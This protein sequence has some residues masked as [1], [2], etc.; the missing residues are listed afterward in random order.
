MSRDPVDKWLD[1]LWFEIYRLQFTPNQTHANIL[2]SQ[3]QELES[4]PVAEIAGNDF[5]TMLQNLETLKQDVASI[6]QLIHLA[7]QL[8]NLR[9]QMREK[10]FLA[11]SPNDADDVFNGFHAWFEKT[12]IEQRERQ[13]RNIAHLRHFWPKADGPRRRQMVELFAKYSRRRL[14]WGLMNLQI[15]TP[16]KIGRWAIRVYKRY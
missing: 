11:Y 9:D 2:Q 1:A 7:E 3:I 13:W 14:K 15:G 5:D 8:R 16:L 12:K 10:G 4:Q 6:E